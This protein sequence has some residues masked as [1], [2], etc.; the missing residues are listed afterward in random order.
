MSARTRDII[1]SSVLLVLAIAAFI[2]ARGIHPRFPTGVGSGY[3]PELA[4]A[5]LAI[6]SVVSLASAIRRSAEPRPT[7]S[8][9]TAKT[10]SGGVSLTAVG[11]TALLIVIYGLAIPRI[12]FA[13][14][15]A[16]YLFAQF[17][18]L[19]PR[20]DRHWISFGLTS[21]IASIVIYATFTYGFKLAL[22]RGY[23]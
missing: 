8:L 10:I 22:P 9:P 3:F 5:L 11:A 2:Y 23:F 15:T 14:A 16:V 21:L 6:L 7:A 1:S 18:L 19:A 17:L 20:E 4:S 13:V 12:G